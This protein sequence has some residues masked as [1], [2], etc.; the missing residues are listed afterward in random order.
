MLKRDIPQPKESGE[1]LEN[2]IEEIKALIKVRL[3]KEQ[4]LKGNFKEVIGQA[5]SEAV[6]LVFD[7]QAKVEVNETPYQD[8]KKNQRI[9]GVALVD[10]KKVF[11]YYRTTEEM[12][13]NLLWSDYSFNMFEKSHDFPS[14]VANPLKEA[15]KNLSP[16]A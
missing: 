13:K 14:P 6:K 12:D 10:G 2:K 9:E 4:F 8:D 15:F 16:G 11:I 3:V 5:L 7:K 1:N